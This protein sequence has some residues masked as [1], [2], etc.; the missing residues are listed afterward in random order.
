[1]LGLNFEFSLYSFFFLTC[2]IHHGNI[3]WTHK[4][5]IC[6][7]LWIKYG[8]IRLANPN[9]FSRLNDL[10]WQEVLASETF[11]VNRKPKHKHLIMLTINSQWSTFTF[12]PWHDPLYWHKA[13]TLYILSTSKH[14][15][16][17]YTGCYSYLNFVTLEENKTGW[18]KE[19]TFQRMASKI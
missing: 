19:V 10:V 5:L 8:L 16:N 7:H 12:F 18:N 11:T 9:D 1:M 14:T 13:V 15:G 4:H 6:E 17:I 3:Y 2:F